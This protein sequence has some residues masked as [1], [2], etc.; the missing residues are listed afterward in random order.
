MAANTP[1]A[2]VS[3]T[4]LPTPSPARSVHFAENNVG[5]QNGIARGDN[6]QGGGGSTSRQA[7]GGGGVRDRAAAKVAV[8]VPVKC[9][10]CNEAGHEFRECPHR[11][12]SALEGSDVMEDSDSDSEDDGG[13]EDEDSDSDDA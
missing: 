5:R 4:P 1:K 9:E 7:T 10:G 12:D 3:P 6:V 13:G 11:S 2:M 8:P